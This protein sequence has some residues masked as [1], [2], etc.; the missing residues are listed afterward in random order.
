MAMGLRKTLPTSTGFRRRLRAVALASAAIALGAACHR[1]DDASRFVAEGVYRGEYWPTADWRTCQPEQVGMDSAE[2]EK[3]FAYV[4]NPAVSTE[5]VVIIRKGYVVA[6]A[7]FGDFTRAS[8]HD[9]YSVAKSFVSALVG[10][11]I[12]RGALPGV[13]EPVYRFFADWQTPETPEGKRAMTVRHLLTMSS[14]LTWNEDDYYG[15]TS[16]N[17]AFLMG[18]QPDFVAYVL[19]K[20]LQYPPGTHW[21]YSS[22][23]SMLLS[24]IIQE[25]TGETTYQFARSR[26]LDPLGLSAIEWASDR[27]GHTVGGWGIRATAREYA[28]LGYL[29]LHR[30][31]WEEQQVVPASWVEESLR[32]ASSTIDFYGY[33]WWRAPALAGQETSV[34][35]DDTFLAWG[36]YTQQVF[37]IPSL[38]LVVAR[39]ANDPGSDAW[40]EVEFL[41]RV[42][43]AVVE[44]G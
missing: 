35:P 22:G 28:K 12:D 43:Q 26:L 33:Q 9:S 34:V 11:A 23:D 2:L 41:T 13:D 1:G 16:Q 15:D 37:V 40:D 25:A 10:I 39:V 18:A 24:A 27:A 8:R 14:G 42:I 38:G 44:P 32:P 7:Y 36:I 29:Y 31:R 4:Q 5:G 17:D 6:E 3:V 21:H 20:P 30:G 19:R